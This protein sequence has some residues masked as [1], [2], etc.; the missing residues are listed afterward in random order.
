MG[1]KDD[2]DFEK[3]DQELFAWCREDCPS[4]SAGFLSYFLGDRKDYCLTRGKD[5]VLLCWDSVGHMGV[6]DICKHALGGGG[7]SSNNESSSSLNVV[8]SAPDGVD[9]TSPDQS[10]SED[11][12]ESQAKEEGCYDVEVLG[13]F[14]EGPCSSSSSSS[15]S[16]S[17]GCD[18]THPIRDSH[19]VEGDVK[20]LRLCFDELGH[21]TRVRLCGVLMW[22]AEL[23]PTSSSDVP[24]IVSSSVVSSSVES[25]SSSS[26]PPTAGVSIEVFIPIDESSSVESSSCDSD[27]PASRCTALE[28][29]RVVLT[30]D[31]LG[32]L[33]S[34]LEPK[35][36]QL[37]CGVKTL[38]C[39]DSL[40]PRVFLIVWHFFNTVIDPSN[41]FPYEA[42]TLAVYDGCSWTGTVSVP[43]C[44]LA[45]VAEDGFELTYEDIGFSL[46]CTQKDGPDIG[47][48]WR[49]CLGGL[50]IGPAFSINCCPVDGIQF[51]G[52][53]NGACIIDGIAAH[54][55]EVPCVID[56]LDLP[57]PCDTPSA[58]STES[59]SAI[60]PPHI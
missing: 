47:G 54:F 31:S 56:C 7:S 15:C 16:S 26:K 37:P 48:P 30:F 51:G 38:C 36:K 24:S 55:T 58:P 53:P 3:C 46:Q 6:D 29:Y 12:G 45:S 23:D 11:E 1:I 20:D 22:Q 14:F 43:C 2:V 41:H 5:R 60:G 4:A 33:F 21:L 9:S 40:M 35:L 13:R 8:S 27:L 39:G 50:Q 25:S 19:S 32:H 42:C 28:V 57:F 17:A 10:S 34:V 44:Q 59:S 49:L 52:F 18:P